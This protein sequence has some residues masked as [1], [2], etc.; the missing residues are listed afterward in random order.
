MVLSVHDF[1]AL[2]RAH[3]EITA[4]LHEVMKTRLEEL[5]RVK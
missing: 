3:P 2:L 5:E 4:S 1:Q